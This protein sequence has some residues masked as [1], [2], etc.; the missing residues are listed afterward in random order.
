S[1]TMGINHTTE[2]TTDLEICLHI[3][4]HMLPLRKARS[5]SGCFI[6]IVNSGDEHFYIT[7]RESLPC[8]LNN[9][10]FQVGGIYRDQSLCKISAI[11]QLARSWHCCLSRR[12]YKVC[13]FCQ[14]EP[15]QIQ[16][17]SLFTAILAWVR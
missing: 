13:S 5:M 2:R 16:P 15:R 14:E 11:H 7:T 10:V 17:L 9:L 4:E 12:F 1:S 6:R 8:T 3:I